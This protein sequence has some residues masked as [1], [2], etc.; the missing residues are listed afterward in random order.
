MWWLI[1]IDNFL[2]FRITAKMYLQLCLWGCFQ[3]SLRRSTPVVLSQGLVAQLEW[4]RERLPNTRLYLSFLNVEIMWP[5]NLMLLPT[6]V[7]VPLW[8]VSS[9]GPT[10]WIPASWSYEQTITNTSALGLKLSGPSLFLKSALLWPRTLLTTQN[11]FLDMG[12]RISRS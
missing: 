2:G 5:S 4:N 8:T 6:T 10:Q 11:P 9:N 3:K 1:F 7:S 12:P